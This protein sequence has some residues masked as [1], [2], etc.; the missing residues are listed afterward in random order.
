[1]LGYRSKRTIDYFQ[2]NS[3]FNWDQSIHGVDLDMGTIGRLRPV[4]VLHPFRWLMP[5]CLSKDYVGENL[6]RKRCLL[7]FTDLLVV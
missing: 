1:M 5:L 6:N 7:L 4:G 2:C 3:I